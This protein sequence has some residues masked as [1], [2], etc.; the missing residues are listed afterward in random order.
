MGILLEA[1]VYFKSR[2]N[3][4]NA[5]EDQCITCGNV[6]ADQLLQIIEAKVVNENGRP[7]H[8]RKVS[9]EEW[10]EKFKGNY[11]KQANISGTTCRL[12]ENIY[13]FPAY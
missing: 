7:T 5:C 3:L 1:I 6:N 10:A 12:P 9:P 2:S 13:R 4:A 8:I 11:E